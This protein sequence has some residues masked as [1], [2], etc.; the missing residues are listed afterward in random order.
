MK[1]RP[2][3]AGSINNLVLVL[4]KNGEHSQAVGCFNRAIASAP[5]FVRAYINLGTCFY[6]IG[7]VEESLQPF[8]KALEL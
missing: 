2:D 8:K 1:A 7:R 4:T 6:S 5:T 3:Y